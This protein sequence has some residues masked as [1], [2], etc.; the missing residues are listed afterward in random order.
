MTGR[1]DSLTR[2]L[3][4]P[5]PAA[6]EV[7]DDAELADLAD[8]IRAVRRAQ[9]RELAQAGERALSHIP[10]LMRGPVRKV[11]GGL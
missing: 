10:R 3:G 6:L 4:A 7:L 11:V 9:A 5:P 8:A 1:L 2:E